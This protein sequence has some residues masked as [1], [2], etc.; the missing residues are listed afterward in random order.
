MS[1]KSSIGKK[2]IIPP[3]E[4]VDCLF[5]CL[6]CAKYFYKHFYKNNQIKFS[7]ECEIE[8]EMLFK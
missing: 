8:T 7:Y 3:S 4:T 2:L 1:K 6:F 5:C